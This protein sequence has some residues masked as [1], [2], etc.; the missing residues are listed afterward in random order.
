MVSS[1][2]AFEKMKILRVD[3][4]ILL[5]VLNS[6]SLSVSLSFFHGLRVNSWEVHVSLQSLFVG[7]PYR[8]DQVQLRKGSLRDCSWPCLR[9]A[10]RDH[11][12]VAD[13]MNMTVLLIC[14][15]LS[16]N[17]HG[18]C[19]SEQARTAPY[20]AQYCRNER[21][22]VGNGPGFIYGAPGSDA[23]VFGLGAFLY[24]RTS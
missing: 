11:R 14:S 3:D 18:A 23:I 21:S 8:N 15:S 24:P 16:G 5:L 12:H 7:A 1:S 13:K 6:Q 22:S 20:L 17:G 10:R 2:I 19:L 9:E 4:F